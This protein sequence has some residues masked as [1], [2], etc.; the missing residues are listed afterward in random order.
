MRIDDRLWLEG[1]YYIDIDDSDQLRI[2][3]PN[4]H[5]YFGAVDLPAS[6]LEISDIGSVDGEVELRLQLSLDNGFMHDPAMGHIRK[7]REHIQIFGRREPSFAEVD[8]D[9]PGVLAPTHITSEATDDGAVATYLRQYGEHY[10]GT[11][12]VWPAGVLLQRDDERRGYAIESTQTKIEVT[13]T[14][15]TDEPAQLYRGPIFQP[16]EFDLEALPDDQRA[17][18]GNLLIRT[19]AE[20]EHLVRAGKTSGFDYGTVFPRDWMETADLI[21]GELTP[22]ALRRVYIEALKH[23]NPDGAGWHEDI[24]GEFRYERQQQIDHIAQGF[25]EFV[26]QGHRLVPQFRSFLDQL[27]ELFVTR[28]MIDIEPH[29]LLGL[30]YVPLG[31]FGPAGLA[32][33]RQVADYV[34]NRATASDIITFNKLAPPFRR[35]SGDEYYDAGNWRDSTLAFKKIHP[36]VAPYDV[37]AV[38]YPEALKVIHDHSQELGMD[39]PRV[40]KLID[41]WELAKERYRFTNTDGSPAMALALYDVKGAGS[42]LSYQQLTVNHL[43]ES[44]SLFYG[45]PEMIEVE[46]FAHRLLAPQYFYTASGPAL[47]GRDDGYDESHYHGRVIWTKQTAY[48]VAGLERQLERADNEAWPASTRALIQQAIVKT[49][50]ASLEAFR[51]LGAIPELHYD[52]HGR[53]RLYTDQPAPE[54]QMNLVQLWSAA[55][56]RRILSAYLRQNH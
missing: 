2:V 49:A 16:N 24:V 48:V 27:D 22:D 5:L 21:A 3:G 50:S 43:D 17:F 29:Y 37:N 12:L 10:Y 54:G 28:Q 36:V 42:D 30:R 40:K 56:A 20:I 35:Q 26:A 9:Y 18:A 32:Q 11:K 47:V 13:L 53:P 1:A 44:Y 38:L 55:G 39:K 25:E 41:K 6:Q 4:N 31:E 45:Q 8:H 46:N 7:V 19:A 34:V 23:V 14:T 15:V 51:Q 33:L 52:D